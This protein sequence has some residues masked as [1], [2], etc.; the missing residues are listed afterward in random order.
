MFVDI[1]LE[2]RLSCHVVDGLILPE[3]TF[4]GRQ[5]SLLCVLGA[6]ATLPHTTPISS[7]MVQ[8]VARMAPTLLQMPTVASTTM[9]L[10]PVSQAAAPT[11]QVSLEAQA[12]AQAGLVRQHSGVV[13]L[14]NSTGQPQTLIPVQNAAAPAQQATLHAQRRLDVP[15]QVYAFCGARI[16][17]CV[18]V[19]YALCSTRNGYF[20]FMRALLTRTQS[21]SVPTYGVLSHRNS[22]RAVHQT[23][24]FYVTVK[25]GWRMSGRHVTSSLIGSIAVL[26]GAQ[27]NECFTLLPQLIPPY[28]T[29]TWKCPR[30]FPKN[31]VEVLRWFYSMKYGISNY[32]QPFFTTWCSNSRM[33]SISILI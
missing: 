22:D 26:V 10:P 5:S 23:R 6:V 33:T 1:D 30:T 2:N 29:H 27:E 3:R 4:F 32:F 24:F 21:R 9:G 14:P 16:R 7:S 17:V 28:T 11:S 31:G 19:R 20:I 25:R 15:P 12:Q 13:N 18:C 8:Q